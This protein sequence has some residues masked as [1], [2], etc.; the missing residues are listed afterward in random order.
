MKRV[1]AILLFII[2]LTASCAKSREGRLL[3]DI[4]NYVLERPDSA[5]RVLGTISST[6]LEGQDKADYQLLKA[7]TYLECGDTS[8]TAPSLINTLAYFD[9]HGPLQK[10]MLAWYCLGM[11]WLHTGDYVR[12]IIALDGAERL[13]DKI[14]DNYQRGSIFLTEANLFLALGS[15]EEAIGHASRAIDCFE[16]ALD[17]LKLEQSKLFLAE[18]YEKNHWYTDANELYRD[19][20]SGN[21]LDSNIR[22]KALLGLASS[23]QA[24]GHPD[25]S[26]AANQH[27]LSVIAAQRDLRSA[28]LR[29]KEIQSIQLHNR[30]ILLI[31]LF[32]FLILSGVF[33]FL[34]F[35]GI[36]K[37]ERE[38]LVRMLEESKSLLSTLHEEKTSL[39]GR[40]EEIRRQYISAYKDQFRKLANLVEC[41]YNTSGQK[42]TR[43]AVYREVQQLA[44]MV[45]NDH[46]T[47]MS[48]ER[49]V[50]RNLDN[51]MDFYRKEYP[52]QEE[53]HYR[54]VCYLMAGYPAS[55][56]QMLTGLSQSNVYVRKN[57]LM[58]NLSEHPSPHSSLFSE[59]LR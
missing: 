14:G 43:D 35:H 37:H 54:L 23:A 29:H 3:D 32:L 59:V 22:R 52:N 55:T 34:L 6:H 57:R 39:S 25:S 26:L 17:K 2:C 33:L 41:Y 10:Q 51:A 12:A 31:V 30:I 18:L 16:I 9:K 48:L 46:K 44:L 40:L 1:G 58:Q 7:I 36:A 15:E 28:E 5:L 8:Y 21:P 11:S 47:Y 56:I 49:K 27:A 24:N 4:W 38:E 53:D 45:G 50:N 42:N 19:I 20:V 13:A